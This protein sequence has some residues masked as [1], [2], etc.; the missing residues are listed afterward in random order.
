[1]VLKGKVLELISTYK[2]WD[3]V[4]FGEKDEEYRR[5]NRYYAARILRHPKLFGRTSY[6]ARLLALKQ[7]HTDIRYVRIRRGYSS[8]TA[9]FECEGI[10]V[11]FGNPQW[12]AIVGELVFKIKLKKPQIETTWKQQEK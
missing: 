7:I 5:F 4:V 3:A 8:V 10:S 9:T 11:G 2:W 12:G 1:M 6:R